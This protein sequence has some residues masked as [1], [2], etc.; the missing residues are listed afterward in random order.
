M[1]VGGL[2]GASALK[3]GRGAEEEVEDDR[4]RED[5]VE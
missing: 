1:V 4:D 5:G 3:E 2:G